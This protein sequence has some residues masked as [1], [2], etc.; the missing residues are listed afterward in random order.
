MI[1]AFLR[2]SLKLVFWVYYR[3]IAVTGAG[4]LPAK[5][6]ILLACNHPNSFLDALVIGMYT[7]RPIYFLARSDVF[8]TPFKKWLLEQMS[9]LPVYRLQEGMENLD[10]NKGTFS[11]CFEL[12]DQDATILIFSEGLCIQELRLRPLKKGT[13]R[14]A[15]EYSKDGKL[16]HI[17]P[18]ALNY[19]HPGIAR[20]EVMVEYMTPF[21]AAE[22][23]TSYSENAG[24]AINEFNKRLEGKLRE[25]VIDIKDRQNEKSIAMLIEAERNEGKSS[26]ELVSLA[27]RIDALAASDGNKYQE[28]IQSAAQ[29]SEILN[30]VNLIDRVVKDK[31]EH[32]ILL[33]LL[34]PF[35]WLGRI[36]N[37]LP[38]WT[39]KKLSKTV[40]KKAEFYDSVFLGTFMFINYFHGLFIFLLLLPFY[41][42]LAVLIPGIL[43]LTGGIVI[44]LN[45]A[46][47][48]NSLRR[49]RNNLPPQE[50]EAARAMRK[51][52]LD[53]SP[54]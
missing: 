37:G 40:V 41:P 6:P 34:F 13:A 1:H 20:E 19:L 10:K 36:L 30:R 12:L 24:R 15:L 25:G 22:F 42:F 16:L 33:F 17:V 26:R 27:N 35:Y 52:L 49:R 14:I 7:T 4:N 47:Q 48:M 28:L 31:E 51:K 8:N 50:L 44:G 18:V 29:Y 39:A 9:L 53:L 43:L 45:D 5:G 23:S 11:R 54:R 21:D 32:S 2:F 3:K 38:F 46:L